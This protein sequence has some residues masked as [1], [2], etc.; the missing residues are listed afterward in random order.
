MP[1]G[2][3]RTRFVKRADDAHHFAKMFDR[4]EEMGE[5]AFA[6]LS[7]RNVTDGRRYAVK[8]I[9]FISKPMRRSKSRR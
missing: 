4:V 8:R 5:G 7:A 9:P 3:P 1:P 2:S 6:V